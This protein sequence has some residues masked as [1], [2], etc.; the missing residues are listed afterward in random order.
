MSFGISREYLEYPKK[1]WVR[2]LLFV[3]ILCWMAVYP[4][5]TSFY[6]AHGVDQYRRHKM[7]IEGN[8]MFFNPWQ[9]RIL[10]PL[11]IEG[12]R[13]T[14][15]RTVYA[16]IDIKGVDL[17]LPGDV[18][19][20]NDSTK[21]LLESLKDPE[22]IKYTLIFLVF[23]FILN[24]ALIILC[25]KYFSLFIKNQLLVALGLMIAVLFMGN[26]V[27]DADMTF[28]T[29]M[30]ISLYILAG[31]LIIQKSNPIWIIV[32]TIIGS[33]NRESSLF[34][35]VLYFFA[36][37]NW[38]NWPSIPK[39]FGDNMKVIGFTSVAVVLFFAI[40]IGIRMYYGNQPVQTWRVSAGWPMLK[41]N[42]FSSV[43]VKTY[44]EFYGIMG[45][46]LFWC[47]LIWR[48]MSKYLKLFFLVLVPVWLAIHFGSAIAYQTRLFLIPTLL[49]IL[50]AVLENLEQHYLKGRTQPAL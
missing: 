26:G 31:I 25:F 22:F 43:S 1:T 24:V 20:K 28:N 11:I 23:R 45:F 8:S 9:Y 34:I 2:N 16:V 4:I 10:C 40:F 46:M 21:Y 50:P 6:K 27:V 3:T 33:L 44:M 18:S 17:G 30:D 15:D 49:V 36:N 42:L 35:P 39:L 38:T 48:S 14:A 5:Y 32:V 19:S 7:H 41:L 47:I 29:Y 13:W 37:F 12:M